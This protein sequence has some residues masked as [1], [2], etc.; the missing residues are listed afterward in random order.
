MGDYD[1]YLEQARAVEARPKKEEWVKEESQWERR[2]PGLVIWTALILLAIFAITAATSHAGD[3]RA[4]KDLVPVKAWLA[5][6]DPNYATYLNNSSL[7]PITFD[8]KLGGINPADTITAKVDG[9]TYVFIV[10]GREYKNGEEHWFEID[11]IVH[12]GTTVY[13][14]IAPTPTPVSTPAPPN[15]VTNVTWRWA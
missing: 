1:K 5:A 9:S 14:Y 4:D 12:N 10:G 11:K 7:P 8:V 3:L 2:M 15:V 13:E 6:N